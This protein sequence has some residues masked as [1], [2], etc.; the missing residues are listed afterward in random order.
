MS[1]PVESSGMEV[2]G[3]PDAKEFLHVS[4]AGGYTLWIEEVGYAPIHQQDSGQIS[5][6]GD[7][8]TD[9]AESEMS[10]KRELGLLTFGVGNGG[11]SIER[12]GDIC[13]PAP[14]HSRIFHC[15]Q[16]L[17]R[18]V[19]GNGAA[20]W[21]KGVPAVVGVGELGP[22]VYGYYKRAEDMAGIEEE[23]DGGEKD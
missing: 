8:P 3:C 23:E 15:N 10:G 17:Y 14:E 12:G 6:P 20:P 2:C 21:G 18:S 16:N 4:G 5:P 19:L 1:L 7:T 9:R 22:G 13:T 11:C